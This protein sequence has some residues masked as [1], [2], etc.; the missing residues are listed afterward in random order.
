MDGRQR[1]TI[2]VKTTTETKCFT[3]F[4][5]VVSSNKSVLVAADAKNCDCYGGVL[6]RGIGQELYVDE[7]GNKYAFS[8]DSEM[9]AMTYSYVKDGTEYT[10][11]MLGLDRYGSLFLYFQNYGEFEKVESFDENCRMLDFA[12][13]ERNFRYIVYGERNVSLYSEKEGRQDLGFGASAACVFHHRLFLAAT[14]FRL[15]YS[16]PGQA[17]EFSE[18]LNESG[19][20]FHFGDGGDKIIAM[21]PLGDCI[22]LFAEHGI[23]KL[24]A[25]GE[26]MEFV[27]ENL[28][29]S[30]GKIFQD[31][32]GVFR[33]GICFLASDG[34]YLFD[35]ATA[36]RSYEKLPIYPRGDRQVCAHCVCG[37]LYLLRYEDVDGE[38]KMLALYPDGEYGYFAF[39]PNG[40]FSAHGEGLLSY[41]EELYRLDRFGALPDEERAVFV[42][43][44][45]NFGGRA[46]VKEVR[47]RGEGEIIV[48]VRTENR[49]ESASISC[50]GGVETA[51]F[52]C[53]GEQFTIE[54]ALESAHAKVVSVEVV[55][56]TLKE[57]ER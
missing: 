42:S 28:P 8:S 15:L 6:K 40:I 45:L 41:R 50:D 27:L 31:S 7:D 5:N 23:S 47:V 3:G 52:R 37:D 46:F 10:K 39:A 54:L 9:A 43:E 13:E 55:V 21:Q 16:K 51:Q 26:S 25:R 34:V 44:K 30:G 32:V 17:T 1:K 35:G 36:K 24:K 12:D 14:P 22:Y 56:E 29:Y 20:I 2:S 33:N 49:T 4:S 57:A 38:N 53:C 48:A 11:T 19:E 18:I